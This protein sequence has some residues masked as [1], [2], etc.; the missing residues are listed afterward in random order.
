M[1]QVRSVIVHRLLADETIAERILELLR[2]KQLLFDNFADVSVSGQESLTLD[3]SSL[4]D[5]FNKEIEKLK[6]SE[7]RN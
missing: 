2:A 6:N 7:N 4:N 5:V 3:E 1:G